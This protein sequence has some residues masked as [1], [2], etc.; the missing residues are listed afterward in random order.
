MSAQDLGPLYIFGGLAVAYIL[1][2][3]PSKDFTWQELTTTGT[4]LPN[5]PGPADRARLV[6]L[7][8]E[9]LQPLRDE[10]GPIRITSAYRSEAVNSA[11]SVRGAPTSHHLKG[12]AADLYSVDGT[13][14]GEMAAWLFSRADLP[15]AEVIIEPTGHLHVAREISGPPGR[16]KFLITADMKNYTV[17]TPGGRANV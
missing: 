9:V 10:F 14:A 16:R 8:R 7:A 4:G 6:L 3:R 17:W 13:T 15:L 11:P 2:R 12:S 5:N 1:V